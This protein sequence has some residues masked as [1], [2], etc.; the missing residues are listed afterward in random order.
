M[1]QIIFF[2]NLEINL[3]N[4]L[5]KAAKLLMEY[6]RD[7]QVSVE[8]MKEL[9]QYI[10]IECDRVLRSDWFERAENNK[11]SDENDTFSVI[12]DIEDEYDTEPE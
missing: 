11:N 5:L 12:E 6:N 1:L 7:V 9:S 2:L 4:L 8:M 10:C 3:D